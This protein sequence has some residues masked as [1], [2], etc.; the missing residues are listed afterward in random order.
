LTIYYDFSS[1][2]GDIYHKLYQYMIFLFNSIYPGIFIEDNNIN[3]DKSKNNIII[4][5]CNEWIKN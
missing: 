4:K 2:D 3:K 1:D 5:V